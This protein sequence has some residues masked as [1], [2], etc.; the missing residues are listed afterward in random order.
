[1]KNSLIIFILFS[2]FFNTICFSQTNAYGN[3]RIERDTGISGIVYVK[4]AELHYIIEGN[5]I[6][7]L[8]LGHS[9]SQR[10]IL[11]QSLR[12][13]FMFIFTDL[14]H[15]AQS[16]SSLE[17]SEITLNTYQDDINAIIDTLNLEK[18]ALFAHSH[19]A[20]IAIEYARKYPNKV[21]HI[22]LTGCKSSTTWGA[23]DEFWKSDASRERKLI[24]KKNLKKLRKDGLTQM[25][26]KERYIK[27][28]IAMTPK[29]MYDT[30]RDLSYIVDVI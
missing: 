20:F 26:P 29:L 13:H 7:C 16:N 17:M 30:K 8:V 14:R 2:Y 15:D 4:G 22:I 6:P 23:G 5:G 9:L 24:F 3:N 1:M 11:S 21:S 28:Y 18:T 12:D 27:T 10:R 25:S 19:H